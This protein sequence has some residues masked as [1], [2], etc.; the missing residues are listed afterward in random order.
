MTFDTNWD[1][2]IQIWSDFIFLTFKDFTPF[3]ILNE[4][5]THFN[6]NLFDNFLLYDIWHKLRLPKSNLN[7][8]HV[9]DMWRFYPW[10][11]SKLNF[12]QNLFD[13][14]FI[15]HLT[16]TETAKIKFDFFFKF[17]TSE[18]FTPILIW[19]KSQLIFNPNLFDN[20]LL[21]DMH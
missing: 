12:D 5:R 17:L 4:V 14:F 8:F 21:F 10:M 18:D 11:K 9:F 20:F 13:H 16:Q 1:S 6:Q 3:L 7:L 2:W 19:M 15:W